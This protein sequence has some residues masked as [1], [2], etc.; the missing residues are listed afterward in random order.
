MKIYTRNSVRWQLSGGQHD[1]AEVKSCVVDAAE[2]LVRVFCWVEILEWRLD[3]VQ[4]GQVAA[5][6]HIHVGGVSVDFMM[7][8][9]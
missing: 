2:L 6:Q 7:L 3:P 9:C 4:T 1:I 5:G 8:S